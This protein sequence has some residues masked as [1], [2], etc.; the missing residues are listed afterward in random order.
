MNQVR[1]YLQ[2]VIA[3]AMLIAAASS[4]SALCTVEPDSLN[5]SSVYT[6]EEATRIFVLTNEGET[7]VTGVMTLGGI[8]QHRASFDGGASTRGYSLAPGAS[9]TVAVH[10]TALYGGALNWHVDL[11]AAGDGL[12]SPLI[13]A[14]A[15]GQ[16]Q[17]QPGDPKCSVSPSIVMNFPPMVIGGEAID[18]LWIS[19]WGGDNPIQGAGYLIGELPTIAGEFSIPWGGPYAITAHQI[20]DVYWRP[21][22]PGRQVVLLD[23]PAECNGGLA[24][25]LRG[26]A[27]DDQPACELTATSFDFGLVSVGETGYG[28]IEITNTGNETLTLAIPATAGPFDILEGPVGRS[29]E[30]AVSYTLHVQFSPTEPGY[31]AAVLDIGQ[32]ICGDIELSGVGLLDSGDPNRLG[33]WFEQSGTTDRIDTTTPFETVTAYLMILNPTSIY[34]VQAWECCVEMQGNGI[35]L[36]WDLAGDPFN[37]LT[38][39]CF[40][41]AMQ[42]E[43]I[44][45]NGIVV[46]A[47][48]TFIQPD[49]NEPTFFYLHPTDFASL[50]GLMSYIDG[51]DVGA[52]IPL[53]PASGSESMP[54]AMVNLPPTGTPDVP[55]RTAL[56]A[57][58]PNPFNPSTT[59]SFEVA[60]E[61]RTELAIHD[62]RGRRVRTLVDEHLAHGTY[63][64]VWDGRDDAGRRV[65]SGV[66]FVRLLAGGERRMMKIALLK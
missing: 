43:P 32:P 42:S 46:L 27:L 65:E 30:P 44:L 9:E 6:G 61:G 48:L 38:P 21:V 7:T 53:D 60:G 16:Q 63:D 8:S 18:D 11:G 25:E 31:Q 57:A 2:A 40:T 19:N 49:P 22:T 37:I 47:T 17:A 13:P 36:T 62:L 12:P 28:V 50:P 14:H 39:P 66:Y 29:L 54:V 3:V 51:A 41:V 35:G 24:L 34:G 5:F 4:A 33:I 26:F 56:K 45:G 15:Y 52:I 20:W 10:V 59:V 23:L 58:T 1:T 64:R 55:A